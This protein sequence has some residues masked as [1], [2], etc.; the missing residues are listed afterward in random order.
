MNKLDQI[1]KN[2]DN[3]KVFADSYIKY[4]TQVLSRIDMGEISNFIDI[5]LNARERGATIFF[6]GNGG[7][8]A[9]ASHFA[10]DIGIG[11]N[12]LKK[13]FRVISLTDNS[14]VI[15]AISN[16]DGYENIFSKQLQ[17]LMKSGDVVVAISASGNSENL[18]K[19]IKYADQ[20]GGVTFG[21]TAFKGGRLKKITQHGIHIT[22][23]NK[24]YGPAEDA[25]MVIDHL[26]NAYL[27]RLVNEK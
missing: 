2:S 27:T 5:L 15:S 20:N 25:H 24:E 21:I 12:S 13:P 14:A 10:N 26:L 11:T 16:D 17:T 18:L 4:L 6:M 3:A 19:A 7:S 9:T 23:G 8:A 22:T 1:F